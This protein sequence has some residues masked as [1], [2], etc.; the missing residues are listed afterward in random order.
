MFKKNRYTFRG[1]NSI[2]IYCP[3]WKGSILEGKNLL[4]VG[5]NCFLLE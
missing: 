2:R 1:G 3:F 4:P 5:V